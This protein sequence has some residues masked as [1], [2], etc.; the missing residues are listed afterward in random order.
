[1]GSFHVF[2]RDVD[3]SSHLCLKKSTSTRVLIAGTSKT[4]GASQEGRPTKQA[5]QWP[6]L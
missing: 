1:M 4:G 5:S 6:V 3:C 2:L